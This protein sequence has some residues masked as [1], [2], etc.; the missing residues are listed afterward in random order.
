[1]EVAFKE[2]I[3]FNGYSNWDYYFLF[4]SDSAIT[5][6]LLANADLTLTLK[7]NPFTQRGC[8]WDLLEEVKQGDVK[9]AS[10]MATTALLP[11]PKSRQENTKQSTLCWWA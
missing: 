1:M 5:Q 7:H 11:P 4:S 6:L 2:I 10:P 3:Y 9:D 8:S